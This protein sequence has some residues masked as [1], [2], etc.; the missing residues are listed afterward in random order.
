MATTP[1]DLIEAITR[2]KRGVQEDVTLRVREFQRQTGLTPS[3]IDVNMIDVT[4]TGQRV[5]HSIVG[6][7]Q[8]R[9]DF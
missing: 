1:E 2:L 6:Q 8:L 3:A 7:V 4:S 9:F 5:R